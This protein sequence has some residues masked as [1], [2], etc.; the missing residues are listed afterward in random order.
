MP[1]PLGSDFGIQAITPPPDNTKEGIL[2]LV[3][4]YGFAEMAVKTI[5]KWKIPKHH[6]M[7][8]ML[9]W[10][11]FYALPGAQRRKKTLSTLAVV[12]PP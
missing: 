2:G 11:F 4:T 3:A 6:K 8:D 7:R 1:P 10:A 12:S 5:F 9:G